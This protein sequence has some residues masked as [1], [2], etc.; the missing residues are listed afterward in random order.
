MIMG[1]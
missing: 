1:Y